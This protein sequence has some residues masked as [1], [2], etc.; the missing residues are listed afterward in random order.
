ML[1]AFAAIPKSLEGGV[2]ILVRIR[3]GMSSTH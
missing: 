2:L 3:V 1:P